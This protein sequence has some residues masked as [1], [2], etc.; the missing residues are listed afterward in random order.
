MKSQPKN[1]SDVSLTEKTN[2][3]IKYEINSMDGDKGKI[4]NLSFTEG[5]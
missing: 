4:L 2:S 1:Y 3:V 5:D